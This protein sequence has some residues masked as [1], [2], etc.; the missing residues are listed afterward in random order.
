MAGCDTPTDEVTYT[1]NNQ[2]M[3][4][5]ITHRSNGSSCTVTIKNADDARKY[6][7]RLEKLTKE[8]EN[9]EKELSIREKTN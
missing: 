3:S 7:E 9:F 6:R 4:L 5:K 8:I 2:E 1:R